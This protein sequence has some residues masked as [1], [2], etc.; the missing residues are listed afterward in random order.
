MAILI[1]PPAVD[2]LRMPLQKTALFEI[3]MAGTMALEITTLAAQ[4]N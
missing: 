1:T 3:N 4:H 2:L